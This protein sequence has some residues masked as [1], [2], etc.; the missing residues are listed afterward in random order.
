[1]LA[2]YNRDQPFAVPLTSDAS[3]IQRELK[4]L[5]PTDSNDH[6]SAIQNVLSYLELYRLS[7]GFDRL[8]EVLTIILKNREYILQSVIQL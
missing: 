8:G 6:Q 7:R 2:T 1:L 5:K 3:I 4:M